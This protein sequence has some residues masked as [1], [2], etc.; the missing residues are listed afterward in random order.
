MAVD[1][2]LKIEGIKGESSD[3]KHKDEIEIESYSWGLSQSGSFGAGGGGGAGK[4]QFQDLNLSKRVG[5]SSPELF[6]GCATGKHYP[7]AVLTARKAG[8]AKQDFLVIKL[9]DV[10]VTSYQTSGASGGDP[11]D[12]FSLNFARIEYEVKE[13]RADGSLGGGSIGG[14]DIKKNIRV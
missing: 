3:D 2:F 1:V 8:E 11:T 4:V 7:T 5:T 13:Q 10:L 12:S 14:W 9:N 6:L